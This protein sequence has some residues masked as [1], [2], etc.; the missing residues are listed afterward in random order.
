MIHLQSGASFCSTPGAVDFHRASLN[1]YI[2]PNVSLA[3]RVWK[4]ACM[5][6]AFR[7]PLLT[8]HPMAIADLAMRCVYPVASPDL[9]GER[10]SDVDADP[11]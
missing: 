3:G 11:R 8:L 1:F 5:E 7:F 9:V 6:V 10:G 2:P 4:S